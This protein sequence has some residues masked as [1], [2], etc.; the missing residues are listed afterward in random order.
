MRKE[1]NWAEMTSGKE[2]GRSFIGLYVLL[3]LQ[4][5]NFSTEPLIE[6]IFVQRV[7]IKFQIPWLNFY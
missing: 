4:T 6:E 1:E 7:L 2:F 3:N 5:F